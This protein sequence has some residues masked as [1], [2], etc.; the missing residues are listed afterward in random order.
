MDRL[1]AEGPS[2][3][4]NVKILRSDAVKLHSQSN[5]EETL[6]EPTFYA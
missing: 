6:L 3:K 5:Q 4:R 2:L 1:N